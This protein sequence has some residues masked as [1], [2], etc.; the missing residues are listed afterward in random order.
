MA[1][2]KKS[3]C[4]PNLSQ[5]EHCERVTQ[6]LQTRLDLL[7]LK[8][9]ILRGCHTDAKVREGE[10]EWRGRVRGNTGAPNTR[11]VCVQPVSSS[12][13]AACRQN[14]F[15][16]DLVGVGL[17]WK[18]HPVLFFDEKVHTVYRNLM[19]EFTVWPRK[20]N[21]TVTSINCKYYF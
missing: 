10:R 13:A 8:L 7:S 12:S 15:D 6:P 16:H 20:L 5:S 3:Y 21:C 1:L 19:R 18:Q 9:M 4:S 11:C 14:L 2:F 17:Q